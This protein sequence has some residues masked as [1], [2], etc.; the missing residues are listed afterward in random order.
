[1]RLTEASGVDPLPVVV[2]RNLGLRDGK[3]TESAGC[4]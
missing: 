3:N 4:L 1:M 2:E